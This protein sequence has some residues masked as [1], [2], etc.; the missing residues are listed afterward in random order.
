MAEHDVSRRRELVRL[1]RTN[2]DEVVVNAVELSRGG[3]AVELGVIGNRQVGPDAG[4]RS[5]KYRVLIFGSEAEKVAD[6]IR[7]GRSP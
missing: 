1:P 7:Q 2:G 5:Y 6:A 4:R 3:R